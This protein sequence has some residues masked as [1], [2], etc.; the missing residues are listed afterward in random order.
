[1]FSRKT[2][3]E[4]AHWSKLGFGKHK[5]KILPWVIFHD[6][7]WFLWAVEK[8][9]FKGSLATEAELLYKKITHIKIPAS[10]GNNRVVEYLVD[11][12]ENFTNLIIEDARAPQVGPVRS[13]W[14]D[15]TVVRRIAHYDKLGNTIIIDV[16]KHLYF[17]DESTRMT[18][19]RC[20]DFFNDH[21]NFDLATA[22]TE[23]IACNEE[24]TVIRFHP[25]QG[26]K[27]RRTLN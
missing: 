27:F 5:G 4:T 24:K 26:T 8:K 16:L 15:L 2:N 21:A 23:T 18:V 19:R 13:K 22:T 12:R 25:G 9:A 14:I 6:L 10:M 7:D 3:V 11:R 17:S 1:M 20:A